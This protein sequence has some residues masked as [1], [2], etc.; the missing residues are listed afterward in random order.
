MEQLTGWASQLPLNCHACKGSSKTPNYILFFFFFK[1][2]FKV[3][4][5]G[6][7]ISSSACVGILGVHATLGFELFSDH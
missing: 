2:D 6:L 5:V 3:A 4:Q 1:R 7:P